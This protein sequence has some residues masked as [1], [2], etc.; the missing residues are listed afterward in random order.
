MADKTTANE[1]NYTIEC[2]ISELTVKESEIAVKISG[3][4]GYAIK[5]GD[6]TCNVFCP[7]DLSEV[8]NCSN[9]YIVASETEFTVNKDFENILTQASI[10]GKKIRLTIELEDGKKLKDYICENNNEKILDVPI[11]SVTLLQK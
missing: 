9:G 8:G 6:R 10:N 1:T 3:T 2:T 7:K 11:K 4:E 5:Q